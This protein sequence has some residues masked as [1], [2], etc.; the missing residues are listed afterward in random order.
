MHCRHANT[1]LPFLDGS[2]VAVVGRGYGGFLATKLLAHSH[3]PVVCGVALAPVAVWQRQDT[4]CSL[5]WLGRPDPHLN[6]EGYSQADLTREAAGL[7]NI[8]DNSLMVGGGTYIVTALIKC[9]P[10]GSRN[11][12]RHCESLPVLA[13][14][15]RPRPGRCTLQVLTTDIHALLMDYCADR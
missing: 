11:R 8:Q 7:A 1:S 6:W 13:S 9:L 4:D 3:S 14:L 12:G 5:A 15:P 10:G 2:R